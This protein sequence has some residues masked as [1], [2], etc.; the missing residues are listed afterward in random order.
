MPQADLAE[1]KPSTVG[2]VSYDLSHSEETVSTVNVATDTLT[3]ST[4]EPAAQVAKHAPP[5]TSS[6]ATPPQASKGASH[7][8]T[9]AGLVVPVLPRE[10]PADGN[11]SEPDKVKTGDRLND[12]SH[13]Q[14]PI[15]EEQQEVKIT[16]RPIFKNWADVA[17]GS[18]AAKSAAAE[19]ESGANGIV[20]SADSDSGAQI[21]GT[22]GLAQPNTRAIAEVLRSYRVSNRN[23]VSFIEPRGLYNS[24]VDCYINSVSS[25]PGSVNT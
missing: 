8:T 5:N 2:D 4:T 1:D 23:K 7:N 22:S 25:I 19:R 3:T 14:A 17:R 15:S 13:S 9:F 20:G 21:S 6:V 11:K 24:S 12:G 10:G 18:A 16:P